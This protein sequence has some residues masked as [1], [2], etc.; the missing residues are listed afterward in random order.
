MKEPYLG[1][2]MKSFIFERTEPQ[3]GIVLIK[4]ETLIVLVL[5]WWTDLKVKHFRENFFTGK[6]FS[7]ECWRCDKTE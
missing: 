4:I 6:L 2:R 7:P 1:V 5:I 3:V